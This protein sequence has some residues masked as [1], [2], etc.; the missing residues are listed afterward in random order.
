MTLSRVLLLSL[1]ALAAACGDSSRPALISPSVPVAL[2]SSY[3][4]Q[5]RVI[6]CGNLCG[7][8][9]PSWPFS[10]TIGGTSDVPS[11]TLRTE[12][13][14]LEATLT[15]RRQPDGL[16]IFTGTAAGAGYV[17]G[18]S[19]DV[20]VREDSERGLIGTFSY[21][22]TRTPEP[23]MLVTAEIVSAARGSSAPV[24]QDFSGT[25]VGGGRG[26]RL[27]TSDWGCTDPTFGLLLARQASG[28]AGLAQVRTRGAQR[29]AVP[30]TGTVEGASL[31]LRGSVPKAPGQ[32]LDIGHELRRLALRILPSG[33]MV[34]DYELVEYQGSYFSTFRGALLAGSKRPSVPSDS[35]TGS[36]YGWMLHETC[37][38]D[39]QSIHS[40][41]LPITLTQSGSQIDGRY[42]NEFQITGSVSGG[43]FV[44]EGGD[45][46]P[47]CL[48]KTGTVCSESLRIVVTGIDA[49]GVMSGTASHT[50]NGKFDNY[51]KSGRLWNFTRQ[52][53]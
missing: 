27:C 6:S 11:A 4:G 29:L 47:G 44:L 5:Y 13:W 52:I 14:G 25:W 39:C 28:Y 18:A 32:L 30:V 45:T 43:S 20:V 8:V 9:G 12:P 31:V 2:T 42:A 40:T 51:T 46:T 50:W 24:V 36:W 49:W 53:Q 1:A 38:G 16:M 10:M 35:V 34:G 21:S 33:E 26:E 37:S 22:A 3:T 48:A 23:S 17:T 19:F 15:G 7:W 41:S